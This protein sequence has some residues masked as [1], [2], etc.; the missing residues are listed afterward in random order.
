MEPMIEQKMTDDGDG[1]IKYQQYYPNS[2]H[3]CDDP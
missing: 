1:D 3:A 2:I